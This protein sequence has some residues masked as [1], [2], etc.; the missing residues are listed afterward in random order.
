MSHQVPVPAY[1][2][3]PAKFT[4][5]DAYSPEIPAAPGVYIFA[6]SNPPHESWNV[7]YVGTSENL[8]ERLQNHEKMS[9]WQRQNYANN[10]LLILSSQNWE[11]VS[12][13]R[14]ERALIRTH[15]PS[16]NRQ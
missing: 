14:Y 10:M 4:A 9:Y 12:R 2:Y 7:V 16:G 3:K 11:E 1:G 15:N 6:G 8:R 5:Y 13:S